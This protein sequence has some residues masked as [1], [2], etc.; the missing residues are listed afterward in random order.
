M[1]HLVLVTGP[2]AQL[3]SILL[4]NRQLFQQ[5][6][7]P[8]F[9][10]TCTVSEKAKQLF[11]E[12]LKRDNCEHLVDIIQ[13]TAVEEL[14]GYVVQNSAVAP[15]VFITLKD[16]SMFMGFDIPVPAGVPRKAHYQALSGVFLKSNMGS[17]SIF[18]IGYE[19]N[20]N[21]DTFL[22]TLELLAAIEDERIPLPP[23]AQ[24]AEAP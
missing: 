2:R 21:F 3:S 17:Q 20:H 4:P 22:Y 16:R 23:A 8:G 24:A 10:T 9:L 14:S 5:L 18:T 13:P 7:R 12:L 19:F 11:I 15:D 6:V 1:K